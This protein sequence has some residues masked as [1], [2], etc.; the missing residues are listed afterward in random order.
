MINT[1]DLQTIATLLNDYSGAFPEEQASIDLFNAFLIKA[2]SLTR[3]QE[4]GHITASAWIINQEKDMALLTHHAKLDL[5]LQLGGHMED[6][7]DLYSAALRE[8]YEESGLKSI[9][10]L[11]SE[12][13]DI[14]AHLIPE[15]RRSEEH[16]HFDLRFL[17]EADSNEALQISPE[18]K[19]LRW[20][21]IEDIKTLNDGLSVMRMVDKM[22]GVLKSISFL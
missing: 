10:L 7:E 16:F 8:A 2:G 19:D 12:L 4:I 1:Q 15:R 6:D 22:T 11:S 3:A 21:K 13:Y 20:V 17:I 14:D 9:K 5:W 18:S